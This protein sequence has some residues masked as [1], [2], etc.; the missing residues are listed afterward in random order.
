MFLTPEISPINQQKPGFSSHILFFFRS[1]SDTVAAPIPGFRFWMKLCNS[2]SVFK[3][4]SKSPFLIFTRQQKKS[5]DRKGDVALIQKTWN[6]KQRYLIQCNSIWYRSFRSFPL[7]WTLDIFQSFCL[8]TSWKIS[9]WLNYS[10]QLSYKIN[11]QYHLNIHS[12]SA[13]FLDI[14]CCVFI[15]SLTLWKTDYRLFTKLYLVPRFSARSLY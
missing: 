6:F 4:W 1:E 14:I 11:M 9:C 3:N 15:W 13:A 5:S 7:L 8:F 12:S 2:A 10:Q